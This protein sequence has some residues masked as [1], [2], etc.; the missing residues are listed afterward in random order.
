MPETRIITVYTIQDLAGAARARALE[1]L[2]QGAMTGKWWDATEADVTTLGALFGLTITDLSFS[3]FWSQGDG[4]SVTGSY[5]HKAGALRAVKRHAPKDTE[6]H[7]IVA[8]LTAIAKRNRYQLSANISRISHQYSH[9]N[10]VEVETDQERV[11]GDGGNRG[12][13]AET[14]RDFMRWIYGQLE[15][16]H[17]YQTSEQACIDSADAN[18]YRFSANGSPLHHLTGTIGTELVNALRDLVTRCDGEAGVRADGSN[19]DTMHAHVVLA[20]LEGR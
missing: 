1:W 7:S 14:L 11:E 16:E 4:A 9:P 5:Q 15:A 13:L 18:D 3:G 8:E 10:T 2:A 19:I 20:K 6:L 12:A 17:T